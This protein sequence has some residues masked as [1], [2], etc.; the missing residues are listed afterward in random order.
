MSRMSEAPLGVVTAA[1]RLL[2]F[3]LSHDDYLRLDRRHLGFGL[4]T[5]WLAGIGRYWDHPDAHLLQYA[6][7]GSVVYVVVLSLFLW[8]LIWP[9]RPA[10]WRYER[11]LT[12][13]TL[14]APP[15]L[16]Y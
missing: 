9:L 1:A 8:L 13:V 4:A 12:F 5:T 15:A 2:T 11:V 3:R 16:L 10:N 6:G 14:T 7:L